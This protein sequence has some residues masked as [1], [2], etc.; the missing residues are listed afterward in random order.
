[1]PAVKAA[2]QPVSTRTVS[3]F[4]CFS[5]TVNKSKAVAAKALKDETLAPKKPCSK[6]L[7][8]CNIDFSAQCSAEECILLTNQF[9]AH[10][11]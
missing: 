10:L 2:M 6:T 3:L 1:M 7:R 8:E 5:T 4:S 9:T 11:C